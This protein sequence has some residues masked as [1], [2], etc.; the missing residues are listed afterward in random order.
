MGDPGDI[1]IVPIFATLRKFLQESRTDMCGSGRGFERCL[2]DH[3]YQ[4][5]NNLV[6]N[7]K[8]ITYNHSKTH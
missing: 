5:T 3:I 1:L 7:T 6:M 2:I 4:V 8:T